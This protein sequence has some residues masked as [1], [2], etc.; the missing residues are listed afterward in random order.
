MQLQWLS[1]SKFLNGTTKVLARVRGV[2]WYPRSPPPPSPPPPP[3]SL[4]SKICHVFQLLCIK[5][6]IRAI[7]WVTGIV[8]FQRYL[9]LP[10]KALSFMVFL[11]PCDTSLAL[12]FT[13]KE[14]GFWNSLLWLSLRISNKAPNG[15]DI[16]Y[17]LEQ[18]KVKK[19]VTA[20]FT[21]CKIVCPVLKDWAKSL[22]C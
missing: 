7:L 16:G 13:W 4:S 3:P 14:S 21:T 5:A 19:I 22:T 18:I 9:Y 10:C 15:I 20:I 6:D 8:L 1:S 2:G 12:K 17:F 11:P